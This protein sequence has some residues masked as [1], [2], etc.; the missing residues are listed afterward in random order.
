MF[1]VYTAIPSPLG[2]K[3]TATETPIQ[4]RY[5]TQGYVRVCN[6]CAPCDVGHLIL[7]LKLHIFNFLFI[8]FKIFLESE[9]KSYRQVDAQHQ[10][11]HNS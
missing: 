5:S 1:L 10:Y 7:L 8:I 2:H 6:T 3:F 9:D 4:I 11:T